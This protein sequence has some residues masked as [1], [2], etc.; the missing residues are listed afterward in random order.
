[1]ISAAIAA[2]GRVGAAEVEHVDQHGIAQCIGEAAA[3]CGEGSALAHGGN[4]GPV[5]IAAV[6]VLNGD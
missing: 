3:G 2:S 4:N 5:G 6:A 1:M